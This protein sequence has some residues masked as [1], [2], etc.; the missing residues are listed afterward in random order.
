MHYYGAALKK[1]WYFALCGDEFLMECSA[2]FRPLLYAPSEH[3]DLPDTLY[4]ALRGIA[5]RLG[6]PITQG[7]VW[8]RGFVLESELHYDRSC[9][10]A[11]TYLEVLTLRRHDVEDVMHNFPDELRVLRRA[12]S[13]Y[14]SLAKLQ[15]WAFSIVSQFDRLGATRQNVNKFAFGQRQMRRSR[16]KIRSTRILAA[17]DAGDRSLAVRGQEPRQREQSA[18]DLRFRMS[19]GSFAIRGK[20]NAK[21]A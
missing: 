11:L 7:T 6:S 18:D 1:V 21:S 3:L 9:A 5:A 17:D 10:S 8:S 4:V 13:H 16:A 20:A 14:L 2:L 19:S 12:R 15:R